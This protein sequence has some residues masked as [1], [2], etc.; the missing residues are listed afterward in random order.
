MLGPAVKRENAGCNLEDMDI[1]LAWDGDHVGREVGR[2]SLADNEEE[3]R[4]ISQAIDHGNEIW[5]SWVMLCGGSMIS[6][7]GDEGRAKIPADKANEIAGVREQYAGAVGSTVTVG[8]GMKL[9]EADQALLAGKLRG[10]DRILFYTPELAEEIAKATNNPKT[11]AEK[12]SDEYL[13]K[14][15]PALNQG[16]GAGIAG[17]SRPAA[18]TVAKPVEGTD[19]HSEAQ[20]LYGLLS[21]ERPGSPEATHAAADFEKQ[22]HDHAQKQ[23]GKDSADEQSHA[24]GIDQVRG[25]VAHVLEQVRQQGPVLAQ[26]REAAPEAYAAIMNMVQAVIAMAHA[27]APA[28]DPETGIAKAE[29]PP[30]DPVSGKFLP[31]EEEIEKEE[32]KDRHVPP[33]EKPHNDKE[34]KK[35]ADHHPNCAHRMK[36]STGGTRSACT[37]WPS[38]AIEKDELK[39]AEAG[40]IPGAPA[41]HHLNLPVG[42]Q[43]GNKVKVQH[44]DGSE[45]WKQMS[46]GMILSQ[47][48]SGHPTSSRTPGS[49]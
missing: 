46:A 48:P 41:H 20:T 39:E 33:S 32:W 1:F 31:K 34:P 45:S 6:Y 9:S 3:L 8:I 15:A 40:P 17:A 44:D 2:A 30:R 43:V 23:D 14:A 37:C 12:L 25:Q 26:M 11:E 47:D 22:L 21:E 29:L 19:E 27:M 35:L 38:A 13:G 10:G 16:A 4:R 18:A 28:P 49:R 5:K 36:P 24:N 7:G 42:S